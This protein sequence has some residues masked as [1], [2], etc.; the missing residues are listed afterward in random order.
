MDEAGILENVVLV[1]SWCS[2]FQKEF[3]GRAT[4]NVSLVTR[5]MDLHI[6]R[7]SAIK[8]R[9][10]VTELLK[11]LSF[12]VGFTGSKGYIRLQHPQLIIEFLVPERGKGS[13]E[14]YP[15]PQL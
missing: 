6:P 5:D 7:P 3:F 2:L 11:D 8:T 15:F 9:V 13:D 4:Y 1:G 10:D 14:P 12:V